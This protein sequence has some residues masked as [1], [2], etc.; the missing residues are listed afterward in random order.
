MKTSLRSLIGSFVI[1]A[2]LAVSSGA[3]ASVIILSTRVIFPGQAREATV[4][5]SNPGKHAALVQV[6]IDKGIATASPETLKVPFVVSPPITRIEPG[7]GQVLRVVYTGESLPADQ[8]S[9]YW[10]NM[11]EVP[12]KVKRKD[13]QNFVQFA[14]RTR[15]K[16]FFRPS[17]LSGTQ[18]DAANGL[19]WALVHEDS[20]YAVKV[21]NDSPYYVSLGKVNLTSDGTTYT[22]NGDGMVAPRSSSTFAFPGL[23]GEPSASATLEAEA[24]NDYGGTQELKPVPSR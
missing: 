6:W 21:T 12:P 5:L 20:G 4:K 17:G 18:Q 23:T 10:F 19:K 11:L 22:A 8:E 7:K 9:V 3:H 24:I 1:G 2:L 16:L 14:F 13:D 15:I